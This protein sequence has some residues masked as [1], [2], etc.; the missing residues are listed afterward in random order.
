MKTTIEKKSLFWNIKNNIIDFWERY[1]YYLSMFVAFFVSVVM[2][3][4]SFITSNDIEQ[5][6]SQL[7]CQNFITT[8]LPYYKNYNFDFLTYL[9]FHPVAWLIYLINIL[10]I[11]LITKILITGKCSFPFFKGKN[12]EEIIVFNFVIYFYIIPYFL[13]ISLSL[14]SIVVLLIIIGTSITTLLSNINDK[15]NNACNC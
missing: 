8:Y 7:D 6:K 3:L 10:T 12:L 15:F 9:T 11:I 13:E 1:V 5:K 2:S 14:I 4:I